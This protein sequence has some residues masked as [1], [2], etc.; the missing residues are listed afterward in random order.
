MLEINEN[1]LAEINDED[2]GLVLHNVVLKERK[3]TRIVA[4]NWEWKIALLHMSN[5]GYFGLPWWWIDDGETIEESLARELLEEVWAKWVVLESLWIVKA[6]RTYKAID[7]IHYWFLVAIEW[8][9]SALQLTEMERDMW[10]EVIRVSIP[11]AIERLQKDISETDHKYAL[12]AQKRS[13]IFLIEAMKY[14]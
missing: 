4:V 11:E 13:K 5:H 12:F 10:I 14:I 1:I 7:W 8:D 2:V 3:C 6:K 9:L